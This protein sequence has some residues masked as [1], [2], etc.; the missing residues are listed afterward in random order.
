MAENIKKRGHGMD[1]MTMG[2]KVFT[3]CNYIF[4]VIVLLIVLY[5]L[6][7]IVICSVSDP[8]AVMNGE[9]LLLPVDFSWIGYE[10]ILAYKTLWVGYG[11]S[12]IYTVGGTIL[13]I[14]L[15]MG[16]A[17]ALANQ[18][19][20]KGLVNF[21]VIFTMFFSGGLIPTFLVM[22]DIGLYNNPMILILMGS[23][24][25]F[26]TMIARTYLQTS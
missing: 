18:F 23:L 11:W 13:G 24:S 8:Y 5:P 4:W 15:T 2:D 22:K 26:N 6:Y 9:V 12:L 1:R 20:G 3:V 21:M 10:K 17:Y 7:L 14:A 19:P 16:L 25:V